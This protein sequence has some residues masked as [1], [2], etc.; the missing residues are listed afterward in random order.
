MML[1]I[2]AERR[3]EVDGDGVKKRKAKGTEG[4][5]KDPPL[6]ESFPSDVNDGRPSVLVARRR[7]S[8]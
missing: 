5:S 7:C 1:R 3:Y 4:C 2:E 8:V 6:T